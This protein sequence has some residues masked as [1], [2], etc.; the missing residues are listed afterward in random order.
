MRTAFAVVA[1]CLVLGGCSHDYQAYKAEPR[2]RPHLHHRHAPRKALR[3][4]TSKALPAEQ[5]NSRVTFSQE[6]QHLTPSGSSSPSKSS[7][8]TGS[9]SESSTPSENSGPSGSS[10]PTGGLT[11]SKS[12]TPSKSLTPG[13]SGN[14]PATARYYVV[15]DPVDSCAVIDTKPSVAFNTVG[16]KDGYP[17]LAA[18]NKALSAT[19]AKCK[20]VIE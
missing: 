3:T 16:D 12:S 1:A 10:N 17:S 8:P 7:T 4:R 18:A 9:S 20:R 2:P 5:A 13:A 19:K 15:L 6:G 14:P 11:P